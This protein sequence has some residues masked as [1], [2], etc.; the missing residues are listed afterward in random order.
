MSSG[1]LMITTPGGSVGPPL[2]PARNGAHE[3]RLS[4]PSARAPPASVR[5]ASRRESVRRSPSPA[6]WQPS[7]Q[8]RIPRA[9]PQ[10]YTSGEP[11]GGNVSIQQPERGIPYGAD[12]RSGGSVRE[13]G[14][15]CA[16]ADSTVAAQ[17]RSD[18]HRILSAQSRL[19]H[20]HC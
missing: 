18:L 13:S 19:H 9:P 17:G 6:I 1:A 16:Q 20:L 2:L 15:L 7:T 3:V 8:Q 10:W 11:S 14:D 5:N 12:D 4:P